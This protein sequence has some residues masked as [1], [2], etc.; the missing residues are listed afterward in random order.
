MFENVPLISAAPENVGQAQIAPTQMPA[1]TIYAHIASDL[2]QAVEIMPDSKWNQV[3]SGTA[4]RWAAEALLARVYLFYTGFYQKD[5]LPLTDGSK[6]A[7]D[8]V[9]TGLNDCIANSGHSLAPDFRSLWPYTNSVS[10]KNSKYQKD[11][12]TWLKDG[13]NPEQVFALKFSYLSAWVGDKLGFSNQYALFFG[14]RD[15]STDYGLDGTYPIG[16]GWG[17]GPVAANLW[18]DWKTEEPNDT[19][20]RKGSIYQVK[21]NLVVTLRWKKLVCGNLKL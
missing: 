2:K 1:D 10:K 13:E 21:D 12:P 9:V 5:A 3:T 15:Q 19:I 7:K 11:A 4:T 18:N 20:R 17:Q 16:Q 6:L 8:F 14:I